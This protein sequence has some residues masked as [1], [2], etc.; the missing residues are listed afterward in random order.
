MPPSLSSPGDA[1]CLAGV[2]L[3][4]PWAGSSLM[5]TALGLPGDTHPQLAALLRGSLALCCVHIKL[6]WAG[7]VAVTCWWPCSDPLCGVKVILQPSGFNSMGQTPLSPH[8]EPL[9][10]CKS[11][12]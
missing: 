1:G 6:G 5:E 7:S 12:G 11:S 3:P 2:W 8:W 4:V 10:L 9:S